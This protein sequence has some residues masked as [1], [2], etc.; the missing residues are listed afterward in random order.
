MDA[1]ELLKLI[2]FECKLRVTCL[3]CPFY[4]SCND[5]HTVTDE[6]IEEIVNLDLKHSTKETNAE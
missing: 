3:G 5:P 6:E 2:R 1:R 4:P